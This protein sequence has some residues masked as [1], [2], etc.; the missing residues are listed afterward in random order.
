[1]Q[2]FSVA[3]NN[4]ERRRVFFHL[5]DATDGI[6]PEA[7]EAGGTPTISFNGR[8]PVN[9]VNTLVAVDASKGDYYL[10]L[11][12]TEI[13]Y[14]GL[15]LLHYKSANTAHFAQEAQ[16]MA[17]DPYT[18]FGTLGGGGGADVDY[19]RIK[20]LID[21]AVGSIP[22]PIEKEPDLTP[23]SEGLQAVITEIRD[24][25]IPKPEKPN[26]DPIL[27]QLALLDKDIR[28][29]DFPKCD[30]KEVLKKMDQQDDLHAALIEDMM[31]TAEKRADDMKDS[32]AESAE[33][34]STTLDAMKERI[35]ASPVMVFKDAKQMPAKEKKPDSA[36][37]L[38]EYLN[39]PR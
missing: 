22:K 30:H 11:A 32:Q 27:K 29:I 4:N 14:P 34:I 13:A 18:Q 20:K 9:T 28:N 21:E 37:I 16:V 3:E 8:T 15:L 31:E 39:L 36:S 12:I 25:D 5:V 1:M 17:F 24:L 26:L 33:K 23:I 19:K 35:D 7:G 6:T 10:E 2:Y 38:K